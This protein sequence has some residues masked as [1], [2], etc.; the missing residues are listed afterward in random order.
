MKLSEHWT[1]EELVFSSTAIRFGIDNTPP[2][3]AIENLK[4]L[5]NHSLEPLRVVAGVPLH[6]DSGYR[7]PQLNSKVGG[8]RDSQHLLGQAADIVPPPGV[9]VE[10]LFELAARNVA[11]DQL[12]QEGTWVHISYRASCRGEML[13]ATFDAN[14]KAHY[15][16]RFIDKA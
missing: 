12:I 16:P 8:I 6:C 3:E 5:V 4:L 1:L 15:T 13:G 2:P 10:E 11:F 14:G 7:C 9:S